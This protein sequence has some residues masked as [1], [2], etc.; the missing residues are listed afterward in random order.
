NEVV[1]KPVIGAV[2]LALIA[3]CVTHKRTTE[4]YHR[5]EQKLGEV[6]VEQKRLNGKLNTAIEERNRV[7][8]DLRRATKMEALGQLAGGIA[9]EINTPIQYIGDNLRFLEESFEDIGTVLSKFHKLCVAARARG[10]METEIG[11]VESAIENANLDFLQEEIPL[12][13]QQS[14]EG[15]EQVS[16]IVLAMKEFSHPSTKE[17]Q[18]TDIKRAIETSLAVCR[19]EWKRVAEVSVDVDASVP[20]VVTIPGEL[21][22]VLLNLVVN[23]AHAIEATESDAMGCIAVSTRR[24]GEW[25]E[26]R[27]TDTGT[28]IPEAIREKV[29]DPFFTTKD[30][31]KGTGQGLA[32]VQNT[33]VT[34]LNGELAYES[35]VGKG[36]TFVI[37]LPLDCSSAEKVAA[38]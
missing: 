7:E 8:R 22:Q 32:I 12:A 20:S 2:L 10:G 33:V 27:V 30:V 19:N 21:N 9:H 15:V 5:A 31:G 26:I 3:A 35:E 37:R 36:T 13:T 1:C 34:S 17:K 11:A 24:D 16:G 25:L 28:G 23:A 29:F 6:T 38:E 4:A 14:L 18:P